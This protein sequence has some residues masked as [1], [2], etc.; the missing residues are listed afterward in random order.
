[1]YSEMAIRSCPLALVSSI[2]LLFHAMGFAEEQWKN[3]IANYCLEC[4]DTD[5]EKGGINLDDILDEDLASH[6]DTWELVVR[7]MEARQMPPIGKDRPSPED[8]ENTSSTLIRSLDEVAAEDP[9]RT[10]TIRRLTRTEYRNAIRDLL[11]L[12][13]D[14]SELLPADE[15]SHGFDNI[16]VGNLSPTLLEKYLGAAQKISR[17]AVGT[18]LSAPDGRT[19]RLAPDLTQEKHV[20]GL[21]LG[22]RGGAIFRHH[23]ARDGEYE[24]QIRLTRDRNEKIEGLRG[25]HEMVVLIDRAKKG[26]IRLDPPKKG[27]DHS[28]YDANLKTRFTVQAGTHDLG[29]TFVDQVSPVEE[30]LRRPY[31][32]HFNVHRHPRLSPA[33]YEVTILGPYEDHGI[34]ETESRDRILQSRPAS[35]ASDEEKQS[36]AKENLTELM[37]L[38]YRRPVTESDLERILPFFELGVED[39]NSFDGGMEAALSAILVSREFLFRIERDPEE[40]APG[41][42]YQISNFELA[43]RLAFFLWSSLPDNELLTAA[44]KG[45][46]HDPIILEAQTARM[47]ADPRATSLVHNFAHQWLY[48]RNLDSFTPDGRLFPD[49]DDNLRRAFRR[50]TELLFES[51]LREDRSVLDLIR[52]KETYLNERLAKHYGI[53]NV[54][55]TRFRKVALNDEVPRG[56]LLRHGSILTVTSYANRTSPVIRGNWILENLLGTPPPPPP[57]NVPAL[58]DNFVSAD[59]PIRERLAAHREQVTCASCHNVIDP[60]GFALENYSAI[61]QWRTLDQER[62]VDAQGGMADGSEFDGVDGLE[63]ALLQ[64]SHIFVRTLSEKL[65]TYA[66][67]RGVTSP[68][69][70]AIREIVRQSKKSD[71]QFSAIISALVQSRPFTMRRSANEHSPSH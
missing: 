8:Y 62:P 66:L 19:F 55:G 59:L 35:S 1:M 63:E 53:P 47:L 61:G 65:L 46:L 69:A 54:Y 6:S 2:A 45:K 13:V 60:I 33:I 31:E 17:L 37:R 29:V 67:G 30:T 38:A 10:D 56:G 43:S 5:S 11:S 49:F 4:H 52:T 22:T 71:Y 42:P 24:V 14:V 7:Q 34:S 9:G 50:E 51:V 12:E 40:I 27:N 58:E 28:T 15:S 3:V 25:R 70:P 23:F 36:A 39:T 44:E 26:T 41:E 64:R 57:P 21:P 32:S 68:D 20:E 48:L 18:P 16:T